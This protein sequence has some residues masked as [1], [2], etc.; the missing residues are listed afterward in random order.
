[1]AKTKLNLT[2]SPTFKSSVNIPIPGAQ[3]VPVEFTFR[4]RTKDEF[5]KFVD[6]MGTREDVDVILDMAT[7]WDLEEPFDKEHIE[8]MPQQYIGSGG[9]VMEE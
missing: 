8:Q 3:A 6:V 9:A 2:A 7:G 5:K 4:G 1:M